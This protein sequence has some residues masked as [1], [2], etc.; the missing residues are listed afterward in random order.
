MYIAISLTYCK[1]NFLRIVNM[2]TTTRENVF[3]F[4]RFGKS[5]HLQ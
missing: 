1:C 2:Q 5:S 4:K 3:L